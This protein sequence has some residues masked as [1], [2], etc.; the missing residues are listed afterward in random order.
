LSYPVLFSFWPL[1]LLNLSSF[2]S[3]SFLFSFGSFF[4]LPPF[5]LLYLSNLASLLLMVC[6]LIFSPLG[7]LFWLGAITLVPHWST[8]NP[9]ETASS[10]RILPREASHSILPLMAFAMHILSHFAVR[11]LLHKDG[12]STTRRPSGR[13]RAALH[14][15]ILAC[16]VDVAHESRQ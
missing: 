6:F 15:G 12:S 3:L 5:G 13:F 8:E 10:L 7:T 11:S 16:E 1:G 9:S 4:L 14:L 2:T